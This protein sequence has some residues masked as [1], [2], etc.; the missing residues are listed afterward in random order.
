MDRLVSSIAEGM[1]ADRIII[2]LSDYVTPNW[3]FAV[4]PTYKQERSKTATS[5]R[6]LAYRFLRE[7]FESHYKVYMRPGLEG[8]DVLGILL[9]HPK[10]IEG[11]K[12]VA[13]IDKDM[14]TLPGLHTNF[15]RGANDFG[16]AVR[17]VSLAAADCYH[18]EQCLTGDSTDGYK[19]CPGV[20]K[21]TA[22]KLLLPFWH[23]EGTEFDVAGAWKAVVEQ[24]V[25]KGLTEVE[26]LQQAR[27]A[28]IC[29]HTEYDFQAKTVRLWTPPTQ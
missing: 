1:N 12:V 6:P 14:N 8:D 18:L 10:L 27:V 25:K 16:W 22:E 11:E 4:L 26:A 21:V 23:S 20:G 19:G 5:R 24:Y 28:R 15:T 7:Y 17:E 2:A 9:T 29:R 3:R 13:S